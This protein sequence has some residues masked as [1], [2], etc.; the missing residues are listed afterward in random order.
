MKIDKL[1]DAVA[2]VMAGANFCI[3]GGK[4]HRVVPSSFL[5]NWSIR[6]LTVSINRGTLHLAELKAP[7]RP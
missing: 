7:P 5:A 3:P 2:F 4:G 6:Q 1:V